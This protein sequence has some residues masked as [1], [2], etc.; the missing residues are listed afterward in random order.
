MISF[1]FGQRNKIPADLDLDR[2][3]Q[4]RFANDLHLLARSEA[5]LHNTLTLL[6]VKSKSNNQSIKRFKKRKVVAEPV[7]VQRIPVIQVLADKT[8]QL[9]ICFLDVVAYRYETNNVFINC[10]LLFI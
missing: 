9:E 5:H 8:K 4:R 7:P 10:L 1:L 6:S 2:S 3:S